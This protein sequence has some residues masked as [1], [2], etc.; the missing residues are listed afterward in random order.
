M[1]GDTTVTTLSHL[2]RLLPS[3]KGSSYFVA[4]G[5]AKASWQ[6]EKHVLFF[7][8]VL[9]GCKLFIFQRNRRAAD[10]LESESN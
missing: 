3:V 10:L 9:N 2:P 1:R 7:V 5:L 4:K 8:D 6:P